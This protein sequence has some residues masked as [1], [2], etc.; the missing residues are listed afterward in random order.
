MRKARKIAEKKVRARAPVSEMPLR[1]KPSKRMANK[2][3]SPP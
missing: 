3:R 2:H 1:T